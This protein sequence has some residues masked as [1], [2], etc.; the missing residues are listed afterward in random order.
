MG[1]FQLTSTPWL[2]PLVTP[3]VVGRVVRTVRANVLRRLRG[4]KHK[5]LQPLYNIDCLTLTW[6]CCCH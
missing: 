3:L 4:M 5:L 2:K 1:V 6:H